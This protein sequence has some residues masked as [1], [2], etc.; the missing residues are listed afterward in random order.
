MTLLLDTHVLLWLVDGDA[1]LG[2]RALDACRNGAVL[3]SSI[4]VCKI[5]IKRAA[6]K[7]EAPDFDSL[8]GIGA[9]P[10]LP[11]TVTHARIA[12]GLPPHHRDPFDRTPVAQTQFDG[13]VLVTADPQLSAYD[14]ALLDATR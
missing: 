4:S 7:L 2:P 6:G 14:A 10:E 3:V 12:G 9:A 1:R 11:F 13:L 5:T 8:L